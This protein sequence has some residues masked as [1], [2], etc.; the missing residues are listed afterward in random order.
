M[1][2]VC[3]G[4]KITLNNDYTVVPYSSK[5]LPAI[6]FLFL[7]SRLN[8][9]SHYLLLPKYIIYFSAILPVRESKTS[10]H[11]VTAVMMELLNLQ[12]IV[13]VHYPAWKY[14]KKTSL[15]MEFEKAIWTVTICVNFSF[16]LEIFQGLLVAKGTSTSWRIN[17]HANTSVRM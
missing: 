8:R 2:R 4:L 5:S 7:K 14:L 10:D 3:W 13:K 17:K 15:S 11:N 9:H 16:I 6:Y 12:W 1:N